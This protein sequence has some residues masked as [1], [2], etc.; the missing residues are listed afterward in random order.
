M[1][2]KYNLKSNKSGKWFVKG[3]GYTGA[4]QK[5]ASAL[6]DAEVAAVI[7]AGF[8]PFAKVAALKVSFAVAYVRDTDLD[9]TTV[10]PNKRNPSKRRF[11]TKDEAIQHGTQFGRLRKAAGDAE[12][13]AGHVGFYVIETNDDVNASIN[14]KTGLTNAL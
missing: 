10:K 6:T 14:W 1:N 8:E 2:K 13:T 9:G 7:A 12:G 5:N 11:A 4:T 3:D